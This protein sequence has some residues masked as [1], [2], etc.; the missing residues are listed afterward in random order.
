MEKVWVAVFENAHEE[1]AREVRVYASQPTLTVL[2]DE[3]G[4]VFG[5]TPDRF[6]LWDD[7]NVNER[8]TLTVAEG[9]HKVT[10]KALPL[11]T[12]RDVKVS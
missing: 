4:D 3:L 5:I 8:Y 6:G 2:A 9:E 10:C 7:P 11:R 12:S 1:E